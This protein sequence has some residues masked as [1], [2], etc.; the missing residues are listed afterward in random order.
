M[1]YVRDPE[2]FQGRLTTSLPEVVAEGST[3]G[4]ADATE[5]RPLADD[6]RRRGA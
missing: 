4:D 2:P 1:A 5:R 3:N 6:R